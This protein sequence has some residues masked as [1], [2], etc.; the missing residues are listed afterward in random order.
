[1]LNN[2]DTGALGGA[3]EGYFEQS[4]SLFNQE[5]LDLSE[6]EFKKNQ[7]KHGSGFSFPTNEG[8]RKIT[9]MPEVERAEAD[10]EIQ[11]YLDSLR[12]TIRGVK[13]N[14]DGGLYAGVNAFHH[15][16]LAYLSKSEA[17]VNID[18]NKI[19]PYGFGFI[20]GL[21]GA[22]KTPE[23]FKNQV[24]AMVANPGMLEDVFGKTKFSQT[25]SE[26]NTAVHTRLLKGLLSVMDE[27]NPA[28]HGQEK[29]PPVFC[30]DQDAYNYF[31]TLVLKDKVTGVNA[32]LQAE[33]FIG[34]LAAALENMQLETEEINSLYVSSCYDPRFLKPSG[35]QEL[36][37]KLRKKGYK[38]IQMIES[39]L[40]SGWI[41]YDIN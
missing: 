36:L 13:P 7:E 18:Y 16:H 22:A 12:L 40:N 17:I 11:K 31:R 6:E 2:L 27:F 34:T 20:V 8:L 32:N 3:V 21:V 33:S 35:R 5:L 1:M 14:K 9:K 28:I 15:G 19:V 23:D 38:N 26:K 30:C 39:F 41:V 10:P 37:K 29:I 25:V 4:K 24:G